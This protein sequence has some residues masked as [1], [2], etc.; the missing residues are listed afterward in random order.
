MHSM[1]SWDWVAVWS[2]ETDC[3]IRRVVE[4]LPSSSNFQLVVSCSL[5]VRCSA[6]ALYATRASHWLKPRDIDFEVL[7]FVDFEDEETGRSQF[8]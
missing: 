1:S 7:F 4:E 6:R 8:C 5:G 3:D 2:G